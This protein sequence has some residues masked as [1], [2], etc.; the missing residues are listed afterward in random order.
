VTRDLTINAS[1]RFDRVPSVRR[2]PGAAERTHEKL[3]EH[4]CLDLLG[5]LPHEEA[6]I[7]AHLTTCGGCAAEAR[8]VG[9]SLEAL[10]SLTAPADPR[11]LVRE[12]LMAAIVA[13]KTSF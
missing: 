8:A 5:A 10:A 1:P 9:I 2:F 13:S 7:H 12:R 11:P 3:R 6:R 4:V